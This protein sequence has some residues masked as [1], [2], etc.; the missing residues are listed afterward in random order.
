MHLW[1][2]RDQSSDL[3]AVKA[4]LLS[5]PG[6]ENSLCGVYLHYGMLF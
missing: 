1:A 5:D 2:L 3:T 6:Y 4:I